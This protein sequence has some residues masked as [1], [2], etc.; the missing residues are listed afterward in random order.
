MIDADVIDRQMVRL[1]AWDSSLNKGTKDDDFRRIIRKRKGLTADQLEKAVT[2][3]TEP[4]MGK[5]TFYLGEFKAALDA[6]AP[7]ATHSTGDGPSLLPINQLH[8]RCGQQ[9]FVELKNGW[10]ICH[11]CSQNVVLEDEFGNPRVMP[12]TDRQEL[13]ERWREEKEAK[14]AVA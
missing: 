11:Q 1:K 5:K 12:W 7:A 9:M 3:L 2:L 10:L 14:A 13:I 6:V 4:L 8:S